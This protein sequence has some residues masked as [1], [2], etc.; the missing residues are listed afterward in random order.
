MSFR[1]DV[2]ADIDNVFLNLNEFAE[3]HII[4]G[5]EVAAVVSTLKTD[6]KSTISS[7]NYDGLHGDFVTVNV[8]KSDFTRIPKQGENIRV[9]GK[10][11]TV[12]EVR[13]NMGMLL[14]ILSAYRMGGAG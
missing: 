3:Y 9:D 13:D 1:D 12:D 14:M 2:L 4:N 5:A 10:R 6:M 11:Y 7:R 8:R